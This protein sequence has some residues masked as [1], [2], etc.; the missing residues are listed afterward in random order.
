MSKASKPQKR[1]SRDPRTPT[2]VTHIGKFTVRVY[3]EEAYRENLAQYC[4]SDEKPSHTRKKARVYPKRKQL[5][6]YDWMVPLGD[7]M[8]G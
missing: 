2:S 6:R 8:T 5:A 1:V 4:D 7:H 3:D